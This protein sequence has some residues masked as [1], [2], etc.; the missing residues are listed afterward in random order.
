MEWSDG[1]DDE[2]D[3]SALLAVKIDC[4]CSVMGVNGAVD[5]CVEYGLVTAVSY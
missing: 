2:D 1:N 5:E 4:G 3:G